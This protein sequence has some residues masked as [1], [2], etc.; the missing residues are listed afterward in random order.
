MRARTGVLIAG[1]ALCLLLPAQAQGPTVR[2]DEAA[3]YVGQVVTVEGQVVQV[4]VSRQSNTT[5]LNFGGRYPDHVF[6]A[7]IFRSAASA[8]PD[9]TQWE[10]RRVH[11][12]GRVRMY[13]GKPEIVLD[14]PSQLAAAP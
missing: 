14:S 12:R 4:S 13:R 7:V 3:R 6:V 9:P 1:C 11:V 10:G 8:F 2:P 5:F